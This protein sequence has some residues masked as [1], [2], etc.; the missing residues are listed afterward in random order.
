ML[1]LGL[2]CSMSRVAARAPLDDKATMSERILKEI[3]SLYSTPY[4]LKPVVSPGL[5]AIG[6]EARITPPILH[7]R[8][9]ITV[10]VIGNHSAGKSSFINWYVEQTVQPTS[11]AVET[12]G[13][14]IVRSGLESQ[15]IKGDGALVDNEHFSAAADR[16]GGDRTRFIENLALVVVC[17][18]SGN[19]TYS[20]YHNP[21][22]HHAAH[23]ECQR[24]WA[25]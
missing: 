21:H 11:V 20:L 7:P 5:E 10:M 24:F 1:P 13:F 12:Q 17:H 6:R 4:A 14:T 15:D 25:D 3:Y 9:R 2:V 16:L 23:V 22:C 18:S 19:R 8:R